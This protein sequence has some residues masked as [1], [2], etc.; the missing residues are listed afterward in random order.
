MIGSLNDLAVAT[1]TFVGG[2]FVLASVPVQ[3]GLSER[4]GAGAFRGVFSLAA[5]AA[6]IWMIL[7]YSEAPYL[8]LWAMTPALRHIT[9][10][11]MPIAT[12]LVVIGLTTRNVTAVGGEATENTS[13]IVQGIVTVTRH[14]FLWGV[15]LWGVAH[16]CSNGDVAS[17]ILFGGMI[18]LSLGGM[19]HIDQRRRESMGA[20]WGPI[21]LTS[22]AVPFLA[23][24]QGRTKIDWMGIG[25]AR[26]VVAMV[27]YA[28][29]LFAHE[30]VIG[31]A[32]I[33]RS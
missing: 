9:F 22:S 30:Y 24:L 14:P 6:F 12:M 29:L 17:L 3:R 21:A 10:V 4:I 31:V 2:H 27:L 15:T 13:D 7:A 25:L 28:I 32:L 11:I 20:A 5:L 19:A 23:A 26:P 8:E 1:A 16:I 33:A 18:I